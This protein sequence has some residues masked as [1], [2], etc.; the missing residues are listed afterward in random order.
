M[1]L[2]DLTIKALTSEGFD[3]LYSDWGCGCK[4]D[5]L[6]P[7]GE[8]SPACA[9]GY[10]GPCDPETCPNDGDCDWHI[11][12]EKVGA[13]TTAPEGHNASFT[14]SDAAGGRSCGSYS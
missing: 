10:L 11:Q 3:G 8:P 2:R 1:N 9:P 12:A 7:C 5:D 4:L 6:M 14:G 13:G